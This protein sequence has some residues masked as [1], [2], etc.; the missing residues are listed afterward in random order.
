[1]KD[2][3]IYNWNNVIS[4]KDEVYILGD[5]FWKT[6]EAL[7]VLPKLNG[8]LHLVAGNHD[9]L[10][11]DIEKYFVWVRN[12]AEIKDNRRNVV[13]CH[14]PIA[15]WNRQSDGSIHLYGHI[16]DGRDER[17][18]KEYVKF[19]REKGFQFNAYNVGCMMDYMNYKPRTL[20]YITAQC[21]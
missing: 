19:C 10:T 5:M 3:I 11:K 21:S 15:H 12:Y 8:S 1:M 6:Q 16:H 7:E 14:Y 20:D 4:D 9:R 13:L 17:P 18:F 2:A